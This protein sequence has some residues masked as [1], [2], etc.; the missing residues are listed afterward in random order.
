MTLNDYNGFTGKEREKY[1][2]VQQNAIK[3]G[4]LKPE[5]ET[6]CIMCGQDKGIRVYH[7]ENYFPERI[8]ENSTPMCASCHDQYHRVRPN[9]PLKFRQ[10]L[11]SVR[12]IPS[13]PRYDKRYWLPERDIILDSYNGFSAE[14]IESSKDIIKKAIEDGKLK[15]LK[16]CECAICGQKKG[17]R[18]YHVEDFSNEE[19]IIET[20]QPVCWTCHQYIHRHKN[21]NP[22]VY[23]RYLEEIK[24]NPRPPVYITNLWSEEND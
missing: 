16:E 15:P 5:E 1:A 17:L 12:E 23:E 21:D 8:V 11:E 19:K 10:Y 20:S 2:R 14:E 3:E 24:E 6:K 4:N 22:E 7:A 13:R 18:E 9:N